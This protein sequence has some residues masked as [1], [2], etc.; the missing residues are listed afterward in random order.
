M[1]YKAGLC[2]NFEHSKTLWISYALYMLS[3]QGPKLSFGITFC[4]YLIRSFQNF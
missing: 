3:K 4:F 1:E 2:L